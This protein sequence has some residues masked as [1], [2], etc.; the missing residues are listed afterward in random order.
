MSI[1]S[2]DIN[3]L[4]AKCRGKIQANE[5]QITRLEEFTTRVSS[6]E[7]HDTIQWD[8]SL[9]QMIVAK[10]IDGRLSKGEP[11][12]LLPCSAGG[13]ESLLASDD[14]TSKRFSSSDH[15]T[16]GAYKNLVDFLTKNNYAVGGHSGD[17]AHAGCI[18][19]GANDKIRAIYQYISDNHSQL[20]KIVDELG[21]R[22]DDLTDE[23]IAHNARNRHVFSDRF[24][25][26]AYLKDKADERLIDWLIGDHKEVMAVINLRAN[27]T[28]N[29]HRLSLEFDRD[30]LAFNVDAW[31][32]LQSAQAISVNAE[33]THQNLVALYYYNLATMLT[34]CGDKMRVS[35]LR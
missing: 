25:I 2:V 18:D 22:V 23:L 33:T 5:T 16:F 31:A 3:D 10:C 9:G 24:K 1:A 27:T 4:G 28:L 6:G 19:C 7:F 30:Y 35:I 14:L 20:R 34:V 26:Y 15:T 21:V 8:E 11:R 13:T 17:H 29:R 12:L 32:F